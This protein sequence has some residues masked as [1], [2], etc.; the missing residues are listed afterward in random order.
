M[1][2]GKNYIDSIPVPI[3]ILNDTLDVISFNDYF[4]N[5]FGVPRSHLLT[6]PNLDE[7]LSSPNSVEICALLKHCIN[8]KNGL[9]EVDIELENSLKPQCVAKFVIDE[10]SND[11]TIINCTFI[12]E[13]RNKKRSEDKKQKSIDQFHK[14]ME[15]TNSSIWEYDFT[16]NS[17]DVENGFLKLLHFKAAPESDLLEY[18]HVLVHPNDEAILTEAIKNLQSNKNTQVFTTR[19]RN[20]SGN[21][22]WLQVNGRVTKY[23]KNGMPKLAQGIVIDITEQKN[24]QN[25]LQDSASILC[26]VSELSGTCSWEVDLYSGNLKWSQNTT[27]IFGVEKDWQ[28]HSIQNFL[29]TFFDL[30]A[31]QELRQA[32]DN[33][34]FSHSSFTLELPVKTIDGKSKWVEFSGFPKFE[35]DEAISLFGAMR[36][37][38]ERVE[39]N[40]TLAEYA[41]AA[42]AAS[43]T[44]S[45]FL[46]NMSHEI[47]T[48]LNGVLGI[49]T[50]L[51]K[52][53]LN[54]SQKSMVEL[55][56]S[57]GKNLATIL[58]DIIDISKI[59]AGQLQL[60]EI[61][62]SPKEIVNDVCALFAQNA[63]AK[64]LDLIVENNFADD[65]KIMADA[66]RLSQIIS[67]LLGNA[68]KFTLNGQVK[69]S[70]N[71]VENT[72][73]NKGQIKIA[74][75]D[76]GI[77]F[78]EE[79][80]KKLFG[81]FVQ[82][83]ASTTRSFG[84]SGLGLSI[85]R[86]LAKLMHGHIDCTS[87][88]NEGS[89]FWFEADFDIIKKVNHSPEFEESDETS[90]REGIKML[91]VE[92][93]QI[94]Q[95]VIKL[96]LRDFDFEILF[97]DN[98]LEAIN[99]CK[100]MRFDLI[101]MD[102]QMP[103]MDGLE[104]TRKIRAFERENNQK[105]TPIITLSANAMKSHI[106]EAK[107]SGAD[108]YISKPIDSKELF[109]KI[110]HLLAL[111][112]D[113][114]S[115]AA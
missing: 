52:T 73:N 107:L 5:I 44:K 69:V 4:C 110:G 49:A 48:P 109:S 12:P 37:V 58:N 20:S 51:E 14:I 53:P 26:A 95:T 31:A 2:I 35:C 59:E 113:S 9:F 74:I 7:L 87:K 104:A 30:E 82:A 19:F 72:H 97:A 56:L 43:E 96:L 40:L 63:K 68:V 45:Q 86:S 108:E 76:T 77:G 57:S 80:R 92:D 75:A 21:W 36:D 101:L 106:D 3:L 100:Q 89:V 99:L 90:M 1:A 71:F 112:E 10:T 47:R 94:N 33:V 29:N 15:E 91:C 85:S 60:S 39:S 93:N 38:T 55:I 28:P 114:N 66:T 50:A 24:L 42:E 65:L 64:G 18:L 88:P 111:Y 17:I 32:I 70:A 11:E 34:L 105:R 25:E 84:G 79:T 115:A 102:T 62:T 103:I 83:D 8:M 16:S 13:I 22:R 46:A 78:N 27:Q 6:K 54:Q 41:I 67:N 61:E 98:G 81:R 23:C